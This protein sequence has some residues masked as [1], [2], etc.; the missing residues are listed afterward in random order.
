LLAVRSV[1][2]AEFFLAKF[3]NSLFILIS[4]FVC[5]KSRIMFLPVI[6]IFIQSFFSG[7]TAEKE[8]INWRTRRVLSWTD[9]KAIPLESAPNAALTSTSILIN[10][11]YDH[12]SL[13]YQLQCVFHPEKSWARVK[14]PRILVHEQGHF[15]ISELFTRKLHKAL[16][17][18]QFRPTS[19]DKDV[20]KIYQQVAEDQAAYQKLYDQETNYSRNAEGQAVW[21]K[22]IEKELN[23]FE[24]YAGYPQRHQ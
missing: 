5:S 16:I 24:K 12:K 7:V 23:E 18:Y 17:E 20:M 9:F 13:T 10:F 3:W 1:H 15:D 19:V 8:S 4:I 22:K 2:G 14:T 21:Q 6:L 11:G